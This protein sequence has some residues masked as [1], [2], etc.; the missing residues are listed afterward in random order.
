[1][2]TFAFYKYMK[3]L[4]LLFAIT[5]LSTTAAFAQIEKIINQDF[6]IDQFNTVQFEL[7][8]DYYLEKWAGTT[9][10]VETKVKLTGASPAILKFAIESGRYEILN[11]EDGDK[12]TLKSKLSKPPLL[13]NKSVDIEEVVEVRIMVPE[14]FNTEDFSVITREKDT[15]SST[16]RNED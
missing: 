2:I 6:N 13:K 5:A 10:L 12:V 14:D 1:M 8:K 7:S 16:I 4:L 15:N 11:I 9:I 3:K